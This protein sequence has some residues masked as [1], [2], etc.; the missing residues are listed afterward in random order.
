MLVIKYRESIHM[1]ENHTKLLT[2]Y[3]YHMLGV[4]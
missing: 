4:F 3:T 2:C 1:S